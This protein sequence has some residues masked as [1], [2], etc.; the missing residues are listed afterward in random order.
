ML[1]PRNI[2]RT[3]KRTL[4][5]SVNIR[6]E[7]IVHAPYNYPDYKIFDFVKAKQDW[8]RRKQSSIKNNSY[9]NQSVADYNS[10]F[11]LGQE[12]QPIISSAVRDF[13][14]SGGVLYIPTKIPADK[15]MPKIERWYKKAALDIITERADYFRTRLRLSPEEISVN[16]NKT[17][18]GV[19]DNKNRIAINWRAILLPPNLL[20]YIIVHEFCHL[21]EFNHTKNFWSIVATIIPDWR[22]V[23]THLKRLGY[24]LMLFRG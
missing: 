1:D 22:T 10:Y 2:I 17:R 20:D 9:I 6:G 12:L 5:L 23:R 3:N 19:C 4:S 15:I 7:L 11:F 21:L 16:N 18:W 24:L 8:I 14:V 13:T